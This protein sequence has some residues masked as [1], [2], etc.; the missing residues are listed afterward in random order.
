MKRR[1]WYTAYS[2]AVKMLLKLW[3]GL[4]NTWLSYMKALPVNPRIKDPSVYTAVRS[5]YVDSSSAKYQQYMKAD[6]MSLAYGKP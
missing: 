6:V 5:R 2:L 3:R 4:E 1:A